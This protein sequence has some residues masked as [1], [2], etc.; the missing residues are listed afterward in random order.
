MLKNKNITKSILNEW[1]NFLNNPTLLTE[2]SKRELETTLGPELSSILFSPENRQYT[3]DNAFLDL[4]NN[5]FKQPNNNHNLEDV[6]GIFDEFR[7]HVSSFWNKNEIID[8][9][10]AG[11]SIRLER[12]KSTYDDVVQFIELKNATNAKS[13]TLINLENSQTENNLHFDIIVNDVDWYIAYPKTQI[14]SMFLGR[15]YWNVEEDRLKYDYTFN[16]GVGEKT[17]RISWC[18]VVS[19]SGNMFMSYHGNM[20]LNMYYCINKK[21]DAFDDNRKLC[22]SIAKKGGKVKFTA[23]TASVNAENTQ[24]EED[25]FKSILQ[26]RYELIRK[27]VEEN[28]EELDEEKYYSEYNLE[29]LKITYDTM[30]T[31]EDFANFG[32]ELEYILRYTKDFRIFDF[33]YETDKKPLLV[34]LARSEKTSAEILEK[35]SHNSNSEVK[36]AVLQNPKCTEEMLERLSNDSDQRIKVAV[37]KN[38]KCTQEILEK[39]SNDSDPEVKVAVLKNPK[40]TQEILEKLSNDSDPKVKIVVLQ[41]PKC[42]EEILEKLSND[43]DPGVKIAVLQNPKCTEEILEKLSN[44]SDPGVKAAVLK[45][46]KCTEE[47]LEKLSND[48][49][50]GVKYFIAVNKKSSIKILEKLSNDS[51]KQVK[52]AV[53]QNP[54]CTQEIVEKLSNDSDTLTRLYSLQHPNCPIEIL[55]KFS[56]DPVEQTQNAI[57]SNPNCPEEIL[58]KLFKKSRN[59]KRLTYILAHNPNCPVD[60]LKIFA[61]SK[62]SN[63]LKDIIRN[64]KSTNDILETIYNNSTF[65]KS[66]SDNILYFVIIKHHN[67]S[68]DLGKKSYNKLSISSKMSIADDQKVPA[69]IIEMLSNDPDPKVRYSILQSN[70]CTKEI[71]TKLST[72]KSKKVKELAIE[73]LRQFNTN[74]SLLYSY[75][76]LLI[77]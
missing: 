45:N 43:S 49:N 60:M 25:Y 34:R 41:N 18:T 53:L 4:I 54:K 23:G 50:S 66:A 13:K 7:K 46:Y 19:G 14:G 11:R 15:S 64:P 36:D 72:D 31:E 40:C 75:L 38:P 71:A 56:N 5:T 58:E 62:E 55:N 67:C 68:I 70:N 59:K 22:I 33:I 29:Q 1:K 28:R 39:L 10:M 42:T 9:N 52:I 35:L 12:Y 65:A 74:E 30:E 8:F 69:Y 17:G 24:K 2:I 27:D 51:D 44:D 63:I 20:R 21:T 16:A 48:S 6:L 32:N 26:D 57:A 47:I 77:N 37:L 61:N 3:N 76:K 73:K